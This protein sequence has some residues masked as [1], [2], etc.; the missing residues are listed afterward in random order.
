MAGIIFGSAG[1]AYESRRQNSS[2]FIKHLKPLIATLAVAVSLT[3]IM[4]GNYA[5]HKWDY[6]AAHK[7]ECRL[8]DNIR[9]YACQ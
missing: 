1:I 4:L 5:M 7:S 8:P 3:G 9:P 2:S 6:E